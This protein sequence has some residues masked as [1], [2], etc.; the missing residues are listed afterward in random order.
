MFG[1]SQCEA[2]LSA[3]IGRS[4]PINEA[5]M[6]R[7]ADILGALPEAA[8]QSCLLV[9]LQ[10]MST[11]VAK[12]LEFQRGGC[13]RT[14]RPLIRPPARPS[15]RPHAPSCHSASLMVCGPGWRGNS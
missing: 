3:L 8:V 6:H 14:I 10:N 15:V 5:P 11:F 7:Q 9:Y 4:W 12:V 1:L 2:E 13:Q